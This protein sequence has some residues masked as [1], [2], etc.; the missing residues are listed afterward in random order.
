MS[1]I[2]ET[3]LISGLVERFSMHHDSYVK[4]PYN[5]T[6][7]RREFI[8]PMWKALGWDIDNER[9]YAEPYK[10]VIH[11]GSWRVRVARAQVCGEHARVAAH[12]VGRPFRERAPLA[13]HDHGI[14]GRPSPDQCRAR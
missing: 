2:D 14:A 11:E 3:A 10:E 8:D 1:L 6:Q 13:H 9:G 4:G 12:G 5:E 7:L